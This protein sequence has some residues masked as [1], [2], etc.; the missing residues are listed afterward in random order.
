[1]PQLLGGEDVELLPR[2][3]ADLRPQNVDAGLELFPEVGQGLAVHQH[4]RP[5]HPGQHRAQWCRALLDEGIEP[6]GFVFDTELAAYLLDPTAG[7]YALGKLVQSYFKDSGTPPQEADQAW[8]AD[9]A[10]VEALYGCLAPK[11]DELGLREVHD[12][13][14][15]PLCPV[16]AGTIVQNLIDDGRGRPKF[17]QDL[18]AGGELRLLACISG[19]ER[20]I[21]SFLSGEDV[22]TH[23]AGSHRRRPM[24]VVT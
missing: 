7:S 19:D 5:L 12:K 13:V 18:G 22:H 8:Y 17:F 20:M 23:T 14:E 24:R 2:Q 11:L 6:E 3:P 21:Q 15:L 16:L 1:M 4:P 9:T 10:W